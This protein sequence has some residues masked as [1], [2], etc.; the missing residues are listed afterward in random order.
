MSGAQ[1]GEG[2][3]A[4][5]DSA[6]IED[7]VARILPTSFGYKLRRVQLAYNRQFAQYADGSEIP[8]NQIG[9]LSLIKRNPGITPGEVATLLTLDAGQITPIL[10]QLV[11]RGFISR[12]KSPSDS[13]SHRLY[14]TAAGEDEYSR[15]QAIIAEL[16]HD[17][18]GAV[19]S[20]K[21]LQQL[22]ATLG[23]LEA[24]AKARGIWG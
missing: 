15:L 11:Q 12:Q 16:D 9:A 10:K 20:A 3:A 8:L 2:A 18:L 6:A 21:D 19:L 5:L 14:P 13:R 17:F 22:L 4:A 7:P 24:A 23:R 1:R